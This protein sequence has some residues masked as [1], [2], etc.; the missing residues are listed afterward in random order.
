[1]PVKNPTLPSHWAG[2]QQI[3]AEATAKH[4]TRASREYI[5]T[6]GESKKQW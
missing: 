2:T 3:E 5:F 4:D 1:M 6:G